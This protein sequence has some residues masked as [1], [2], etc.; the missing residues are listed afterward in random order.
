MTDTAGG[1]GEAHD[2]TVTA[3]SGDPD[4]ERLASG[5][6]QGKLA[7]KASADARV[8]AAR[9]RV[10]KAKEHLAGAQQSL[11]EALAAQKDA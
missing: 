7:A 9:A 10:A 8:T 4:A 1:S 2:A 3:E 11:A 5:V 6:E